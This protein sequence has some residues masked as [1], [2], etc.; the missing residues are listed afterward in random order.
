[1]IAIR[2]LWLATGADLVLELEGCQTLVIE[3]FTNVPSVEVEVSV[4]KVDERDNRDEKQ[5][6]R[7]LSLTSWLKRIVTDFITVW[8]IMDVVLFLPSV[9]TTVRRER[10]SMVP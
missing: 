8:Q 9:S 6:P 2:S 5:Q 7:V 1:L 10:V 3:D 4:R